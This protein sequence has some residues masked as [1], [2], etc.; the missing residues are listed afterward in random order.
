MNK[1]VLSCFLVPTVVFI[2]SNL[3]YPGGLKVPDIFTN[4]KNLMGLHRSIYAKPQLVTDLSTCYFYHT[5]DIPGYGLIEGEWDLRPNVNAYY[6]NINFSEKNVLEVGTSSGFGT[7]TLE[8]LGAKLVSYDLSPNFSWDIVPFSKNN[9]QLT[10]EKMKKWISKVNRAYWLSHKAFQSKAKV[11]YGTVYNIPDQIGKFDIVTVCAILMHLRDPFLALQSIC[12]Y[13][14]DTIIVTD[15]MPEHILNTRKY[16]IIFR[17]GVRQELTKPG[18][19]GTWWYLSPETISDFLYILGFE[20]TTI[21]FHKQ[22]WK[23]KD[24]SYMEVPF[25]TVVGH[26]TS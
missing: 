18:S 3:K 12:A 14:S 8:K 26:R 20:D 9:Y 15:A 1:Q 5:M 4:I 11:V 17:P 16:P 23:K 24:N 22:L 21:S 10:N 6:G 13:V 25:Y 7:F 2:E 19:M